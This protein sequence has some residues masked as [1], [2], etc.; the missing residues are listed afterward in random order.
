MKKIT[1]K[2]NIKFKNLIRKN[3][4]GLY[5][6]NLGQKINKPKELWK[7]LKVYWPSI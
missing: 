6:T 2:L 5:G 1:K 4:R 3:K 7:T